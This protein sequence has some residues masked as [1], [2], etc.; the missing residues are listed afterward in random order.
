MF[1]C[2]KEK[3]KRERNIERFKR[4]NW[5]REDCI[6]NWIIEGWEESKREGWREDDGDRKRIGIVEGKKKF[7]IWCKI[8]EKISRI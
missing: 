6:E 2:R 4:I 7:K 8:L 1:N 3:K 5:N